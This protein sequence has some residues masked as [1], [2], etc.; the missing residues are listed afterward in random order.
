[1]LYTADPTQYKLTLIKEFNERTGMYLE[2]R[3]GMTFTFKPQPKVILSGVTLMSSEKNPV[4]SLKA[5][6]LEI[7]FTWEQLYK[8]NIYQYG[9]DL[10]EGSFQISLKQNNKNPNRF[11]RFKGTFH[12]ENADYQFKDFLYETLE[13]TYAGSLNFHLGPTPKIRGQLSLSRWGLMNQQLGDLPRIDLISDADVKVDLSI[14]EMIVQKFRFQDVKTKFI[15]KNSVLDLKPLRFR[16][17]QGIFEAH[18]SSQRVRPYKTLLTLK[19]EELRVGDLLNSP[20]QNLEGGLIK[21]NIAGEGRG[22]TIQSMLASFNGRTI[23]E[24]GP[25]VVKNT[26]E[27]RT[28]EGFFLSLFSFAG[29]KARDVKFEC[30]V[31]KA[32]VRNGIAYFNP[33]IGIQTQDANI[34]GSGEINLVKQQVA[35]ELGLDHKSPV[36]LQVGSFDNYLKIT[37][38]IDR[39]QYK[40][41]G[42]NVVAESGSILAAVVTGGVSLIAQ[43]MLQETSKIR[44]PCEMVRQSNTTADKSSDKRRKK[45]NQRD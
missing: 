28:S 2:V 32:D 39:P 21:L 29:S 13:G 43:K 5:K 38:P 30:A 34:L 20:L 40:I 27:F 17:N 19:G 3:G 42:A 15:L 31:A 12:F 14:Q 36:S 37:G 10:K 6:E 35:I 41:S 45:E 25:L 18:F 9:F 7:D 22:E 23:L 11:K 16:L 24:M 33:G 4:F 1:M 8:R 26:K 44:N